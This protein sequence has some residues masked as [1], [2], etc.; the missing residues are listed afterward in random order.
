ME[1][2]IKTIDTEEVYLM[3]VDVEKVH[4]DGQL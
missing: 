3:H 1:E 4:A 2:C